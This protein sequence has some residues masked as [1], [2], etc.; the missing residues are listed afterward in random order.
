[1]E[2]SRS[3]SRAMNVHRVLLVRAMR[4]RMLRKIDEGCHCC[5]L[6]ATAMTCNGPRIPVRQS[7]ANCPLFSHSARLRLIKQARTQ[8]RAAVGANYDLGQM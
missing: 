6:V 4:L 7:C 3:P 1:M 5:R 2:S 8:S